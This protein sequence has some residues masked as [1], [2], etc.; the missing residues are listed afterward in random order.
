[1]YRTYLPVLALTAIMLFSGFAS[2][3]YAEE[4]ITEQRFLQLHKQLQPA[5]DEL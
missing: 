4:V 1:M 3:I 2:R 5:A